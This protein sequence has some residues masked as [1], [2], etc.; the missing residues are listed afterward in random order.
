MRTFP[1][2]RGTREVKN[3]SRSLTPP[4]RTRSAR[5]QVGI[6]GMT[7][8]LIGRRKRGQVGS[9]GV[10]KTA[11]T[12]KAKARLG[13]FAVASPTRHTGGERTPEALY[14]ACWAESSESR[15]LAA[16]KERRR[17]SE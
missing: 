2:E 15:F 1:A 10:R 6:S 8:E 16:G 11:D 12:S 4:V 7:G 13:D 3:N 14:A 9:R 17:G 5:R